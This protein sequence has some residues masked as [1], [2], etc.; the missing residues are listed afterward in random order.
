MK[1]RN[2]AF[3]RQKSHFAERKLNNLGAITACAIAKIRFGARIRC[4]RCY[5]YF[6][7]KRINLNHEQCG[8]NDK[9]ADFLSR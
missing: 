7:S 6:H 9:L 4:T 5:E 1:I 2:A 3:I 8:S